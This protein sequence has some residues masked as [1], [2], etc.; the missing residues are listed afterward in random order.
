[1]V[2][3]YVESPL[4]FLAEFTRHI[5]PEKRTSDPVLLPLSGPLVSSR[6]Y[7][8]TLGTRRGRSRDGR[9]LIDWPKVRAVVIACGAI[10]ILGTSLLTAVAEKPDSYLAR[11]AIIATDELLEE[12]LSDLLTAALSDNVGVEL[13]ERDQIELATKELE[14]AAYLGSQ[15]SSERLKLGR[16]LKAD[17]LV[18][19]S[20]VEFNDKEFLRV[21][22]SDCHYGARLRAEHL[23]CDTEDPAAL[24]L[25]CETVVRETR[26]HYAKGVRHLI[27][28][29]PF[30]SKNFTHDYDHLQAGYKGLVENALSV[31]PGVAVLEI[32]E[33]RAIPQRTL[34]AEYNAHKTDEENGAALAQAIQ[35]LVP[36]DMLRI[37]PGRYSVAR[38]LTVDLR[39]TAEAPIW[40]VGTHSDRL[41]II[42]RP[43]ARQNVMNV[44]ERSRTEY[45]CF[46]HLEFTGGSTLI[47]FYD[48]HDLWLDQ[49]HLHH[50]G[51]EGITTNTRDTSR[52]FITRNHF[53]DFTS[54]NATG[55]A[56]YLGANYGKVVMSYSVIAENHVH[57]CGGTQGD[58]IEV[59]QGSHHNWIYRNHVHDTNYPCIIAYGTDGKGLNV[60]E[61]NVCYRSNDNVLQVQGEAIVRNNLLMAAQSAGFASTDH[62]GKTARLT[63]VHNTIISRRR[64]ANLS[65]WNDRKDM[66]FSNNVVYTDQGDALRFPRGADGVIVSGNVLSG[67]VTGVTEGFVVGDDL[68]DFVDVSWDGNKRDAMPSPDCPFIGQAAEKYVVKV[69]ITGSRRNGRLTAGAFDAP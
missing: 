67:R 23:P 39:G 58:G 44:G 40:I 4:A 69:D 48:C 16:I 12:G 36:G 9:V 53:H 5:P 68:T 26:Q 65:S 60:I 42:T 63:F 64:G 8:T 14:L 61:Q 7:D 28:V 18:L 56:M 25:Q 29:T 52:L 30:L 38:K 10:W 15:A 2:R 49:C 50:A 11:W 1:M 66:A 54:P 31:Y 55:E 32:D 51:H 41:P 6:T 20:K 3:Q 37:G 47:R 35:D 22:V 43:D 17:A 57:H 19:L 62:Q 46:R 24:S 45:V 13:V 34:R 33:A 59:K 21:I 27:A